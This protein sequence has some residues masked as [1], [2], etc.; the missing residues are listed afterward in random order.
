MQ[1]YEKYDKD[2]IELE[3]DLTH[4]TLVNAGMTVSP[5]VSTTY[6]PSTASF[7]LPNNQVHENVGVEDK[8]F[9]S[10]ETI[11]DGEFNTKL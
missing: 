2:I 10:T 3:A 7:G 11:P 4:Q 5:S 1:K 9:A 8:G 6:G